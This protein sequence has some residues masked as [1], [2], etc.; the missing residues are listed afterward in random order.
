MNKALAFNDST[1]GL[2][3]EQGQ[4]PNFQMTSARDPSCAA[5]VVLHKCVWRGIAR[6]DLAWLCR[7]VHWQTELAWCI[8]I[9][10]FLQHALPWCES[11]WSHQI[12]RI[13]E[14]VRWVLQQGL[15]S[16]IVL[17]LAPHWQN[18]LDTVWLSRWCF[19]DLVEE[20]CGNVSVSR[21]WRWSAKVQP[22]AN[23]AVWW[24]TSIL[25]IHA[26]TITPQVALGCLSFR[27]LV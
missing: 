11:E 13:P 23:H 18:L 20:A 14:M 3:P 16:S 8:V 27:L 12:F 21:L 4:S 6:F 24:Y 25:F 9:D 19:T 26:S 1:E 15:A 17:Q 5:L 22:G 7:V 10:L 2:S